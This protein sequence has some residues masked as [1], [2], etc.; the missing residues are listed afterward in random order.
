MSSTAQEPA[1]P[2]AET[3]LSP[4][5]S[6]NSPADQP[7][8]QDEELIDYPE[9]EAGSQPQQDTT[10]PSGSIQE[11][12]QDL[13]AFLQQSPAPAPVPTPATAPAPV[14]LSAPFRE[15]V[16]RARSRYANSPIPAR[17]PSPIRD[18]E[19]SPS[20]CSNYG[21]DNLHRQYDRQQDRQQD[22]QRIRETSPSN[23]GITGLHRDNRPRS[24]SVNSRHS[25]SSRARRSESP[26]AR[27]RRLSP[28][29]IL[30][31]I[32]RTVRNTRGLLFSQQQQFLEFEERKLTSRVPSSWRDSGRTY[33]SP[34]RSS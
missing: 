27:R 22:R 29:P 2:I 28:D 7:L 13:Q 21:I 30:P 11:Q 24:E 8:P 3:P 6:T 14:T 33:T 34:A 9:S 1:D 32:R 16:E 20:D 23:Y 15:A 18:R 4:T 12:D 31:P 26:Y 5:N 25:Q 17:Q 10:A 19:R